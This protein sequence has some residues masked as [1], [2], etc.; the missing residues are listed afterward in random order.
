[1]Y[2]DTPESHIFFEKR[3]W[4]IASNDLPILFLHSALSTHR[5]FDILSQRYPNRKQI[6]LDYPAHGLSTTTNTNQTIYS[7]ASC[8]RDVL[9][10]EEIGHVDIIGYSMG[11]YVALELCKI[12]PSMVRSIVT[13]ATKFYWDEKSIEM[14]QAQLRTEVIKSR[15][16]RVYQ[17]LQT[18]HAE[19]GI[20]NTFAANRSVVGNF[21]KEKL[22]EADIAKFG[23]PLLLSVGDRDNLVSLDEI[24]QLYTSQNPNTT[25]LA[26]HPNSPHQF[27]KLDMNSF[28]NA[29]RIFWKQLNNN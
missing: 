7:L 14:S 25:S 27:S 10:H 13:H 16:E 4:E 18:M 23:I 5:E 29:I 15:S 2:F 26:I 21:A 11:G 28:T 12:A 22:V 9:L 17:I 20:E 3:N 24:T 8:V 19:V 1:M 6:F